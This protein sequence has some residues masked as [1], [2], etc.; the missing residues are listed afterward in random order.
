MTIAASGYMA[1]VIDFA[2]LV[3]PRRETYPRAYS[4]GLP[5]I[6][7]IFDGSSEGWP[8][9][10]FSDTRVKLIPP[11]FQT[12]RAEI[13]QCR[14]ATPWVVEALDVIEHVRPGII[15]CPINLSKRHEK[16]LGAIRPMGPRNTV[17][18]V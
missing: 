13:A 7:G 17:S 14:V 11:W 8:A 5:K 2:G 10:G 4:S 18:G 15:S 3:A 1:V 12:V 16:M 6:A 9:A